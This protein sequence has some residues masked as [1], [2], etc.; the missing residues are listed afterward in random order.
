[1]LTA[2]HVRICCFLCSRRVASLLLVILA[3]WRSIINCVLELI[4]AI[5]LCLVQRAGARVSVC[6]VIGNSVTSAVVCS[7]H[8]PACVLLLAAVY[9][10]VVRYR[11]GCSCCN[12]V[13]HTVSVKCT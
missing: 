10:L 9:L 5:A 3:D 11:L 6:S 2:V 4:P 13:A 8:I 7:P 12:H 1:M